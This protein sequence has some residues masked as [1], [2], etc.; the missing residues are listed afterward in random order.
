MRRET[1]RAREFGDEQRLRQVLMNLVSNGIR[2]TPAGGAV[3]VTVASA[4]AVRIEDDTS[5]S[6]LRS[7]GL[8]SSN[9]SN[10]SNASLLNDASPSHDAGGSTGSARRRRKSRHSHADDDETEEH[11]GLVT[12]SVHV[13]DT[14]AGILARDKRYIF[15]P[16]G[17]GEGGGQGSANGADG[18]IGLALSQLIVGQHG[19]KIDISSEAGVRPAGGGR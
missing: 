7:S 18:G 2:H 6:S 16:Y 19:G 9:D 4:V 1:L 5:A 15:T 8:R 13:T 12:L 17:R 3:R 10:D 11:V 14:G